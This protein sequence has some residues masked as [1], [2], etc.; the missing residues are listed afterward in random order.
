MCQQNRNDNLAPVKPSSPGQVWPVGLV[1]Q[2]WR[3]NI[4]QMH[5]PGIKTQIKT[6]KLFLKAFWALRNFPTQRGTKPL[7][8]PKSLVVQCDGSEVQ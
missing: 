1:V 6:K 4:C 3:D 2:T 7:T 8:H 5:P